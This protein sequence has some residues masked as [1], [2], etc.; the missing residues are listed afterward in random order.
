ML[1]AARAFG[2]CV[3]G[4]DLRREIPAGRFEWGHAIVEPGH[5]IREATIRPFAKR[6]Q[7][8][9]ESVNVVLLLP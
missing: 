5:D 2:N 7:T 8:F 1:L 6:Y 9:R 4:A 3:V